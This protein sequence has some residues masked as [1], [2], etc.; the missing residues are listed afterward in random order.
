MSFPATSTWLCGDQTVRIE[1]R[2]PWLLG[3]LN[4]TPD[5]FSDGGKYFSQGEAVRRGVELLQS[6]DG[7]DIGGESTRPGA[8]PVPA[9]EERKRVI[10]VLKEIRKEMPHALLSVDTYK[11]EVA[12]AAIEIAGVDV[13]NDVGAGNWDPGMWDVIQRSRVGYICMHSSGRPKEMQVNPHYVDVVRE[14]SQFLEKKRAEWEGRKMVSERLVYDV[15]IGFGK[16]PE[17]NRMLLEMDWTFLDRPLVWGLSRKSFLAVTQRE[18]GMQNRDEALNWWNQTLL[19]RAL[20][21]IWRVH[22]PLRVRE[23]LR[24]FSDDPKEIAR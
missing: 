18:K 14:V 7:L 12:E 5:S 6:A 10:S 22:D 1:A 20:P 24:I 16:R 3:I 23:M 19:E 15:G 11:A 13:V 2:R 21:M 4:V 17:D 9:K 8:E